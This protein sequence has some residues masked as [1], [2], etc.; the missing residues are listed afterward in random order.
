MIMSKAELLTAL[1]HESKVLLHL[2]GKVDRTQ[3]DYRPTPKQ[4]STLEMLRYMGMMGPEIVKYAFAVTP[5]FDDWA[6]AT[7]AAGQ[8][9]YDQAVAMIAALPETYDALLAKVPEA[10]FRTEITDFDEQQTS[11]GAFLV[12]LVIGGHAAYRTQIFCYLKACGQENL[13]S[14]NLWSGMDMPA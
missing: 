13:T 2:A 8:R 12:N 11:R 1:T 14:A 3:L 6:K 5:S 10:E 4:R 9:D 7:E